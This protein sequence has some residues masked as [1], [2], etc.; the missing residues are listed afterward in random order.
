MT[1]FKGNKMVSEFQ[2]TLARR[3]L[4]RLLGQY[5]RL[6]RFPIGATRQTEGSLE[7]AEIVAEELSRVYGEI[8]R[9]KEDLGDSHGMP[10]TK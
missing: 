9:L 5:D 2:N 10:I 1:T 4:Q 8:K 7:A 6:K 3:E